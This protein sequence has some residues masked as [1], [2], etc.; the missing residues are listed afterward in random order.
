VLKVSWFAYNFRCL[1]LYGINVAP[2][3]QLLTVGFRQPEF[4]VAL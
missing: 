2:M 4:I 3:F 1:P